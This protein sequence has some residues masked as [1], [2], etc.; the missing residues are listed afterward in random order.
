[1]C[2][3]ADWLYEYYT[4]MNYLDPKPDEVIVVNH[5]PWRHTCNHSGHG[6]ARHEHVRLDFCV[7][8]DHAARI[9][10]SSNR[11]SVQLYAHAGTA[12]GYEHGATRMA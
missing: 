2:W 4:L 3:Y 1:M 8:S 9:N 12:G 7:H 11:D 5:C 6:A 10:I